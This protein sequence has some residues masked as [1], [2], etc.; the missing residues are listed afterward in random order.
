MTD[1][2]QSLLVLTPADR[3]KLIRA[4]KQLNLTQQAAATKAGLSQPFWANVETGSRNPSWLM[5]G[6]MCRVI[7][8]ELRHIIA[9]R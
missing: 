1:T 4:R 9:K 6:R 2:L 8:L 5:L 3:A 7:G